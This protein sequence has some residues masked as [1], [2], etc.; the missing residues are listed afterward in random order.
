MGVSYAM[1][2]LSAPRRRREASSANRYGVY[3]SIS[4]LIAL[5]AVA[6]D[7]GSSCRHPVESVLASQRARPSA[8]E[9]PSAVPGSAH[10]DGISAMARR[11]GARASLAF[12]RPCFGEAAKP[13]LIVVDQRPSMF[14]G[15]RRSMK[16]AAAAEAA[17]LCVWHVLD[18]GGLVGGVVFNDAAV[19]TIKP[20]GPAAMQLLKAIATQN[21]EL[22]ADFSHPRAPSK[23]NAALDA[24]GR[25][26]TRD[27]LIV[28]VSDFDGN[29]ARTRELL[30]RLASR[31]EV[32][33][34]LVYDP[35]QIDLAKAGD[36]IVS[37]GEL[38]I[39]LEFG[40]GR[41]RRGVLDLADARARE[42]LAFE[43]EIGVPV[44]PLSAAEDTA[45]Q[46]R[47]LLDPSFWRQTEN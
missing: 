41:I 44:L 23:F 2:R 9:P 4:D 32:F 46:M 18:R 8:S 40:G 42:M 3:T 22:R 29:C 39:N 45:S 15:S 11:V 31:N 33:A 7:Y 19:A 36:I 26:S 35:F 13:A 21:G 38:Q 17:A 34:V 47:R 37:R 1:G 43:R 28:V 6:R 20:G 25:L 24:A 5:R 27:H 14:C 16:S 12:G 10:S 30:M